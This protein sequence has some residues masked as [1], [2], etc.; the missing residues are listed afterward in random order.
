MLVPVVLLWLSYRCCLIGCS[1]CCCVGI[2]NTVLL[3]GLTGMASYGFTMAGA[4]LFHVYE[5]YD[6][7][8]E[9]CDLGVEIA[10]KFHN[11]IGEGNAR[12]VYGAGIE[13][14]CYPVAH[15]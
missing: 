13:E 14:W 11:I 8:H 1:I 5:E 3:Y 15:G 2:V 10:V 9:I 7:G 6:F 4:V 12:S